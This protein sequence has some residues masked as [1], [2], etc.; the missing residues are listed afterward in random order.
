MEQSIDQQTNQYII[1]F[2]TST[3]FPPLPFF[4]TSTIATCDLH[5][6]GLFIVFESLTYYSFSHFNSLS[7]KHQ[8]LAS[9]IFFFPSLFISVCFFLPTP[10]GLRGSP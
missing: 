7:T 8:S 1:I 5:I 3:V 4:N 2:I 9:F 10:P 6:S